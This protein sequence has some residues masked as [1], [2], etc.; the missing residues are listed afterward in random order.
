MDSSQQAKPG[1]G[2]DELQKAIEASLGPQED[3]QKA[4]PLPPLPTP[5]P[6]HPPPHYALCGLRFECRGS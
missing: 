5:L 3:M 1:D 2:D 4:C 6:V